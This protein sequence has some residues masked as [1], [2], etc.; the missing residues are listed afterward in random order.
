[1]SSKSPRRAQVEKAVEQYERT[2]A[3]ALQRKDAAALHESL[4]D[5]A[6]HLYLHAY[7]QAH[8]KCR[9][10]Y[11]QEHGV[12]KLLKELFATS[13]LDQKIRESLVVQARLKRE[14]LERRVEELEAKLNSMPAVTYAGAFASGQKY[15]RGMLATHQG[16]L[17]HAQ[18]ETRSTPG[19]DDSWRLAVKRGKDA[20]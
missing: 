20:R 8:D 2:F 10:L 17:W 14:A 18:C 15:T 4:N 19:A 3:D 12:F 7:Y 6:E 9:E 5:Q 13:V 11:E 1:M 16:S